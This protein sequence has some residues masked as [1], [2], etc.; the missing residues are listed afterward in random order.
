MTTRL[1]QHFT[2]EELTFSEA[3]IRHGIT[4]DPTPE[5][6][7]RLTVVANNLEHIRSVLGNRSIH[8]NSGFRSPATN[9][10]VG[11]SQ[12][13]A[14]C[15]GWAVDF[16]CADYGTPKSIC[17]AIQ[18]SGLKFDQCIQ[19]FGSWCHISFDPKMR[20]EVLT[21]TKIKGKTY[22]TAGLK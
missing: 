20:Q 21:A 16:T 11:G 17:D 6:T 9:L 10:L 7:E 12:T 22:Y 18:H 3:A 14:H 5:I 2:L 4:N 13:S 15:E 1:S 19:E 8:I